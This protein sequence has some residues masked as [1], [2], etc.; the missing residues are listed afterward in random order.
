MKNMTV[1]FFRKTFLKDI[2]NKKFFRRTQRPR[3][4]GRKGQWQAAG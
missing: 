4:P 2:C 1:S 3:V